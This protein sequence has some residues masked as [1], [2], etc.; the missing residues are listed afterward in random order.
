MAIYL[1]YLKC[2]EL[3]GIMFTIAYVTGD[4]IK[5]SE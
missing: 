2:T 3:E 5:P 4:Q 1:G